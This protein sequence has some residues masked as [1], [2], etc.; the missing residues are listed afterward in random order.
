LHALTSPGQDVLGK[1]W[2]RRAGR[3][4]RGLERSNRALER[5]PVRLQHLSRDALAVADDGSEQDRTVD[6]APPA[7]ASRGGGGL[8]DAPDVGRDRKR[9]GIAYR[10]AG[11]ARQEA[12]RIGLDAI[13]V[14]AARVEDGERVGILAQCR[15]QAIMPIC[16]VPPCSS[17]ALSLH[18]EGMAHGPPEL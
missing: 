12:D 2:L 11:A 10:R 7:T 8:E 18:S 6:V 16:I 15:K 5:Q 1:W 3:S 4:Q 13:G 14:D 9:G 17:L